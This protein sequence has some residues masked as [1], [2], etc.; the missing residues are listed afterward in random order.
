ML[1][2]HSSVVSSIITISRSLSNYACAHGYTHAHPRPNTPID[3][4]MAG[5]GVPDAKELEG[6]KDGENGPPFQSRDFFWDSVTLFVVGAILALSALDFITEY[7]RGSAVQCFFN[8]S[9]APDSFE[10]V[11]EYV[12][13]KCAGSLPPA[14]YLPAFIAVHAILILAPHYIW[15]NI[16]GAS[17]DS[18]FHLVSGLVRTREPTTGDYPE[19][20]Y[21]ISKQLDVFSSGTHRSNSMYR[22]YL[23]K[24]FGQIVIS[25]GGFVLVVGFFRDFNETFTC[26]EDREER[27]SDSWP[28]TGE[29]VTCVFTSLRLLHKIW[30]IYLIL[31]STAILCLLVAFIWLVGNHASELSLDK[32]ASFSF[33]TSLPFHHF[34]PPITLLTNR[35]GLSQTAHS[36]LSYFFPPSFKR[37]NS[38]YIHSDYDFLLVKLF[39]TDGGLAQ[40]LREVHL[41]RLLKDM[42]SVELARIKSHNTVIEFEDENKKGKLLIKL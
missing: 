39:R 13:E 37:D 40:V 15:L 24:L 34:T 18:F 26:P 17:I 9:A 11:G 30:L 35:G 23:L 7:V 29:T 41:L 14:E 22:L 19:S 3:G 2:K 31:L 21:V 32:V 20:N 8:S 27:L 28:L 42:N 6:R 33:Q 10:N 4:A 12:N 38:Y 5:I 36:I 16:F 1:Y 25:V